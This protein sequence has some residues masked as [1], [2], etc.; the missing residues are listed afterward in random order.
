[1]ADSQRIAQLHERGFGLAFVNKRLAHGILAGVLTCALTPSNGLAQAIAP[2]TESAAQMLQIV[3]RQSVGQQQVWALDQLGEG[4][5]CSRL[6][7]TN[8][9]PVLSAGLEGRAASKDEAIFCQAEDGLEIGSDS[10]PDVGKGHIWI[11]FWSELLQFIVFYAA[12]TFCMNFG[13][14]RGHRDGLADAK[15][16]VMIDRVRGKAAHG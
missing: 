5:A 11:S 2:E 3:Q 10:G 9:P 12:G 4:L 14:R 13:Y 1:M 7:L 15:Y 16:A 6:G 8:V